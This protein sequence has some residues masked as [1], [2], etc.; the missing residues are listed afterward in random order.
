MESILANFFRDHHELEAWWYKVKISPKL[1]SNST[2]D[3]MLQPDEAPDEYCLSK[4]LGI[5]MK[6]L[7][8]VLFDCNLARKKGK[9]NIIVK[10]KI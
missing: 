1:P 7:W 4:L 10:E 3:V 5:S 8:R 2:E 6:E 9:Q